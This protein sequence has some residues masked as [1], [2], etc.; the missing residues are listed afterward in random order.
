MN[1][2]LNVTDLKKRYGNVNA[3]NGISFGVYEGEVVALLGPNGAGKTTTVDT[4]VGLTAKD[5]GSIR[6]FGSERR[7][8]TR[9]DKELIGIQLQN[10]VFFPELT[11][12]E[13]VSL[14]EALYSR[15]IDREELFFWFNLNEIKNKQVRSL[16]GGQKQRLAL[17]CALTND[18][19]LVFL[20]EPTS[21]I[22]VQNRQSLWKVIRDLR[23]DGRG[24]VLTTHYIE[25]AER[26]ADRVILMDHG[27]IVAG[28]TVGELTGRYGKSS[29][30]EVFL[31]IT[32][33][34]LR[35]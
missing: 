18:P 14:F 33:T 35:D 3:V 28:G 32:G 11:V 19:R 6:Y 21:G 1:E 7:T 9:A 8:I 25:E 12:S 16:S 26:L 10:T 27:V 4:I 13:I 24:I 34:E 20:D 22:D 17:A 29:L 15:R 2:L 31:S 5:G 23:N 30:E